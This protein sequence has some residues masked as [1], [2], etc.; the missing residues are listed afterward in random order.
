MVNSVKNISFLGFFIDLA[1]PPTMIYVYFSS[2]L[3]LNCNCPVQI[4]PPY[5]APF[6]AA[7]GEQLCV[8]SNKCNNNQM[9]YDRTQNT[10]ALSIFPV[11]D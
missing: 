4:V 2:C 3:M 7:P 1:K 8:D 5:L 10:A 9:Y 6:Q 11:T